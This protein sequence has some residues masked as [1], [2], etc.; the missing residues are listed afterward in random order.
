MRPWHLTTSSTTRH[1]LFPSEALR[2]DAVLAIVRV[3]QREL[4][5]FCVVDDHVHVVVLCDR[6]RCGHLSRGL[7]L[8]LA[9][10]AAVPLNPV[11]ISTV[12]G[13]NHMLE[14]HRYVLQQPAH[15]D[16]ASHPALWSG[17]CVLDLVGARWIPDLELRL[18]D[19][20]PRVS[21]ESSLAHVGLPS[22]RL[23]AVGPGE[24]RAA[25]AM[26]IVTAASVACAA[27]PE[28]RGRRAEEV[29]ARRVACALA[30]EA[31]IPLSEMCWALD[32][33]PG[34]AR[35]LATADVELEALAATRMYLALEAAVRSAPPF[36][37]PERSGQAGR[38]Q[39]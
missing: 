32:I 39:R 31:G 35:K 13:H 7:K 30:R 22:A 9:P 3:C 12:H 27:A 37:L 8:A 21:V 2:R 23:A 26:A 14:I 10:I 18:Y 25:G 38:R 29:R 17:S 4:V 34:S 16:L 15:H 36:Q 28:L 11:H 24:L 5:Q 19:T 20:L 33:H 1:T 6:E